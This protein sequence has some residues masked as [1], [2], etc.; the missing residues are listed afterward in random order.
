[1]HKLFD[2]KIND[3]LFVII[4]PFL[5]LFMAYYGFESSYVNMKMWEKAPDF[6]FSSVYAY[7]VIPNYLSIHAS[8][9]F[10]ELVNGFPGLKFFLLKHGSLFYHSVFVV[11]SLFFV[12]SSVLLSFIFKFN[13]SVF[14]QDI[15]IKRIAHLLAVFFIVI[16]QY[17]PTNCDIIAIFFYLLGIL[18]SLKYF[19]HKK[20]IDFLLLLALIFVSTFVRETACLNIAFFAAL[21]VNMNKLDFT[22]LKEIAFLVIAFLLPYFGLKFFIS[23]HVSF[24]EGVYLV[25]NFTSPF[26]LAGLCFGIL[27]LYFVLQLCTLDQQIILKKYLLF[28]SPYIVMIAFVGLFWETRLFI[29]LLLTGFVV[30]SHELKKYPAAS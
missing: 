30:A 28:S 7:R 3:F 29:P 15:R 23:Q 1:M 8:E 5:L 16:T 20:G 27:G 24:A 19:K 21:F 10:T 25:K 9:I 14:F 6:M 4:F 18:L 26:N 11:N 12:L 17:V 13:P 22:C 2:E